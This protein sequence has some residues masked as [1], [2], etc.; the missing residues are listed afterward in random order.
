[1]ALK[2]NLAHVDDMVKKYVEQIEA[3]QDPVVD[4]VPIAEVPLEII[5]ERGR[6][7]AVV[8]GING[9]HIEVVADGLYSA[10]LEGYYS[11]ERASR[12]G[13]HFNVFLDYFIER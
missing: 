5:D 4:D 2:D 11:G 1:M 13:D 3:G 7:F 9:P 6:E 10:R 12:Y 8:L